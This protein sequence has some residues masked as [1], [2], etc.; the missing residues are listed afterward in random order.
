MP[1]QPS[2][3]KNMIIVIKDFITIIVDPTYA[4]NSE[5]SL[6]FIQTTILD[7]KLE[8]PD[9]CFY[10]YEYVRGL[11][12]IYEIDEHLSMFL[13]ICF[14]YGLYRSMTHLEWEAMKKYAIPEIDKFL[15]P[16]LSDLIRSVA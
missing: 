1:Y 8:N 13:D 10:C 11:T 12:C 6:E 3:A 15:D 14:G 16:E 5:L 7:Y 2:C 4:G 9:L